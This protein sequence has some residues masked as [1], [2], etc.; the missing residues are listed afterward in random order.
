MNMSRTQ[1]II[2]IGLTVL[3]LLFIYYNLFTGGKGP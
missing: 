1:I 3:L 2:R